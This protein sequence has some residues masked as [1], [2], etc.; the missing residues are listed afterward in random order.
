MLLA[1][2]QGNTKP[3]AI[4][5]Y[6]IRIRFPGRVNEGAIHCQSIAKLNLSARI[7]Q[8]SIG[9]FA[10]GSFGVSQI[11]LTRKRPGIELAVAFADRDSKLLI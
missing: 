9:D 5:L 8:S 1:A 11:L 3:N 10:N 6:K 4:H 2:Q 7:L